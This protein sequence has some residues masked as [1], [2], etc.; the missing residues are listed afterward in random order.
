MERFYKINSHVFGAVVYLLIAGIMMT[1]VM[2]CS[3]I[4]TRKSYAKAVSLETYTAE[5]NEQLVASNSYSLVDSL[6]AADALDTSVA[7]DTLEPYSIVDADINGLKEGDKLTVNKY[8]G[9]SDI[10]TSDK[11]KDRASLV[12]VTYTGKM[13]NDDGSISVSMHICGI[14]YNKMNASYN[15][16]IASAT[17]DNFAELSEQA[18]LNEAK[19]LASGDYNVCYNI[20]VNIVDG[21][22]VV[23]E[24]LKQAM[25]CGW[26]SGIGI[27]LNPVECIAK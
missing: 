9:N 27:E 16:A 12:K 7:V 3:T 19:K 22:L 24:A 14:D 21:Q 8:F 26:Y 25:T 15:E 17:P 11:V 10:F 20:S 6:V 2:T 4:D 1:V 23:S 18:K 5:I 13:L